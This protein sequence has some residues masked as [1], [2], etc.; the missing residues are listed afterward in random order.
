MHCLEHILL[1]TSV[2][3][4][5]DEISKAELV[6]ALGSLAG[7]SHCYV[8][9]QGDEPAAIQKMNAE[10]HRRFEHLMHG[11]NSDG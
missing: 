6:R 7:L 9:E 2:A 10:W 3:V 4:D 11:D 8:P 1:V 5:K